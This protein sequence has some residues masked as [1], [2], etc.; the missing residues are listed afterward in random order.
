MAILIFIL[1]LV[2]VAVAAVENLL[3][4]LSSL[5]NGTGNGSGSEYLAL[6]K[7]YPDLFD[8]ISANPAVSASQLSNE[9]E[10]TL[11]VPRNDA[12]AKIPYSGLRNAFQTNDTD[13]LRAILEYHILNGAHPTDSFTSSFAFLPTRL[14]NSTYSNVTSGQVVGAVQQSPNINIFTSGLGSRSTLTTP[15]LK[16]TNGLV[17]IIDTFLTSPAGFLDT[18]AQYNLTAFAGALTKTNLLNLASTTPDITIF[19]P[20]NAAF[21]TVASNLDDISNSDLANLLLY[22]IVHSPT[23]NSA[24][25]YSPNLTNGTYL[26]TL[27]SLPPP[28]NEA[29]KAQL[30]I[31]AASNSV[32]VNSAH[33]DQMDILLSNGVIH[34][35]DN[36]L[37]PNDTAARPIPSLATQ[38]PVIAGTELAGGSVPFTMDFPASVTMSDIVATAVS[39]SSGSTQSFGIGDVGESAKSARTGGGSSMTI[40]MG[41]PSGGSAVAATT[42]ATGAE[43]AKNGASSGIR[44]PSEV[45]GEVVL[46]MTWCLCMLFF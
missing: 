19:I 18:T 13:A 17:H 2:T 40:G 10:I 1:I 27:L 4:V 44:Q 37:S 16:Y 26:P 42:T 7:G 38:L 9:G 29:V 35:I 41:S 14:D 25:S 23:P 31:T 8:S 12:F 43:T 21:A 5:L 24:P 3:P 30:L 6:L 45:D 28:A 46:L 22:H 33:I 34:V 15:D 11:L 39:A 32:F 36:V 20:T